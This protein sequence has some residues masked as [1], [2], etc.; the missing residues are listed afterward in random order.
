MSAS[1]NSY[2]C[3]SQFIP[4]NSLS[5]QSI[6]KLESETRIKTYPQDATI[7]SIGDNDDEH[8]FLLQGEIGLNSKDGRE[9]KILAGSVQ[10]QYAIANL[11]PRLFNAKANN[12]NVVIAAVKTDLLDKLMIWDDTVSNMKNSLSVDEIDSDDEADAKWRM[13]MLKTQIFLTLPA[14]NIRALFEKM[15]EFVVFQ[16]ESIVKQGEI[17]DYYYIIKEGECSVSRNAGSGSDDVIINTLGPLQS[18][19]EEALVTGEPRNANVTMS[20]DGKLMRLA[21]SDFRTLMEEPLLDLVDRAKANKLIRQ[22]SL[23]I[24]VRMED[25]YKN[26]AIKNTYNIPLYLL[27]LK[28]PHMDKNRSYVIFCDTGARSAAAAFLLRKSGFNKVYV[29]K[30]GL[31]VLAAS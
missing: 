4:V 25:E 31:P 26:S 15:E 10:S 19:G 23:A 8:L 28:M 3:L 16:G 14:T 9:S 11:K 29:L 6:A 12:E 30:D 22:G 5:K 21:K 13:S 2:P 20:T 24:D 1:K 27:R 17:G 18:F 7:F